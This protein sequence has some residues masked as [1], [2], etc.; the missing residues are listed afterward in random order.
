MPRDELFL[1]LCPVLSSQCHPPRPLW[2]CS[3]FSHRSGRL[4]P[5]MGD[6][7]SFFS[8]LFVW[9]YRYDHFFY[10][11]TCATAPPPHHPS[12]WAD[13]AFFQNAGY[14]GRIMMHPNAYDLNGF[15]LQICCISL[16][17]AFFSAAIYFCLSRTYV[18]PSVTSSH[19]SEDIF[20]LQAKRKAALSSMANHSPDSKPRT[21]PSSSYFAT[22]SL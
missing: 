6:T 15:L 18:Q 4:L 16:A 13:K 20:L 11:D 21:T 2:P 9:G 7:G 14:G 5:N 17:P 3:H 22:L 12:S 10:W 1:W 8:W 19:R